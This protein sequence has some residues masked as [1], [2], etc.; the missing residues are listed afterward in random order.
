MVAAGLFMSS[1]CSSLSQCLVYMV[2]PPSQAETQVIAPVRL[3]AAHV[4]A[5][6]PAGLFCFLKK[7]QNFFFSHPPLVLCTDSARNTSRKERGSFCLPQLGNER[8][9]RCHNHFNYTYLHINGGMREA[10]APPL[11]W[12]FFTALPSLKRGNSSLRNT[13]SPCC[14]LSIAAATQRYTEEEEKNF[15]A[16]QILVSY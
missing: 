1:T 11:L 7:I 3:F 2:I 5:W 10:S 12:L 16:N 9:H 6:W 13:P 4:I 8:L 14:W 15:K